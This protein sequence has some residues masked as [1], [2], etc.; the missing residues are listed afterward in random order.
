MKVLFFRCC[1]SY[2]DKVPKGDK[3]QQAVED[4]LLPKSFF[5]LDDQLPGSVA[6]LSNQQ[7]SWCLEKKR[8]RSS[9]CCPGTG[10][11]QRAEHAESGAARGPRTVP[12]ELLFQ[13]QCREPSPLKTTCSTGVHPAVPWLRDLLREP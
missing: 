12:E 5:V 7:N 10:R 1:F 9:S 3:G 4:L 13:G 8:L 2:S 11:V 6:G